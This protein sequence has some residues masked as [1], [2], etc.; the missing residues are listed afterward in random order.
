MATLSTTISIPDGYHAQEAAAQLNITNAQV[1]LNSV[2]SVEWRPLSTDTTRNIFIADA[3]YLVTAVREVHGTASSSGTLNIEKLTG[4]TA[5]GSGTAMLTG[6][7][8]LAGTANTVLSGTLTATTATL[9]LAAG[10]RIGGVLA[11]TLTNLAGC[12]V[13]LTMQRI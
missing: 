4:T 9:T 3:A 1:N 5:A 12:V 10:D 8:S 13:V 7:I 11:G 2:K 6:T